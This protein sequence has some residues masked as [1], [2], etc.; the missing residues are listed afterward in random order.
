MEEDKKINEEEVLIPKVIYE[1]NDQV[2]K[3]QVRHYEKGT[4]RIII[5]VLVGLVM[6]W[7]SYCYVQENFIPLKIILALPYKFNELMHNAFHPAVYQYSMG[8][9]LDEFFPQAPF[10]SW[11]AEHGISALFGGA[12]YGSLAYFTGDK[13]IFTLTGY[14]KF[15]LCWAAVIGVSTVALFGANG[16]Q[17]RQNNALKNVSGFFISGESSGRGYYMEESAAGSEIIKDNQEKKELEQE[18]LPS[19][20]ELVDAFYEGNELKELSSI[21]RDYEG[22]KELN[23]YFGRFRQGAMLSYI[24]PEQGYLVTDEGKIYQMSKAFIKLYQRCLEEE[25]KNEAMAD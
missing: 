22:E 19:A 24:H 20:V 8:W 23:L 3:D 15:G 7:Y 21:T 11:L 25:A 5:F 9:G 4:R 18:P 10:I 17:V 14:L 12:I 6:G 13:R 1:G 16:W 2:L